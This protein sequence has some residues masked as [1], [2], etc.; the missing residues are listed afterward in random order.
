M[1]VPNAD[2]VMRAVI[3]ARYSSDLQAAASI[4][5]QIRVCRE[6]IERDG[7]LLVQVY[8]DRAVSGATLIRPG[9]QALLSDA[10]KR[11]F[12]L[13]YVESLD[14]IS[15]DQQDTPGVFKRLHFSEVRIITLEDGDVSELH[16]GLK[17]T[18]NALFL[19]ALADKTRRGLRGRVE[20]GKSGGGLTYGYDVVRT[21]RS[22]GTIEVG[23]R[24]VNAA[25]AA[26]VRRIFEAYAAGMPPRKIARMLNSEGIPGPRRRGWGASTIHGNAARGTGI[27]NNSLYVGKFVWNKLKYVKDPETGRRRSRVN[28][29]S[30]IVE[31]DVPE[32]RVITDELWNRVKT[33]QRKVSFTVTGAAKK[34]WDR[35]RPRYL[36]S[37]LVK[38]GSCG[39]GYVTISRT[40]LGCATARNKGLCSNHRAV[41]RETLEATIIEALK[42]RLM[43]PDLFK[44][45]CDEFIKE[46]NRIRRGAGAERASAEI[47]LAKIKKRQRQIVN[48]IA[49]GISA[50]TLKDE[51]MALEAREDVLIAKLQTAPQQNVLLNPNMA[52]IYRQRV[53]VLHQA[54][55]APDGNVEAIEA[56]RSLIDRIAVTPTAGKLTI[57]LYGEI[58]AILCMAAGKKAADVPVSVAEQLVMVAGVGFEPTTFRL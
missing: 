23:G 8:E 52:E 56:V 36:L 31:K 57:D 29:K 39:G 38:C 42:T 53:A 19:K 44:E 15:R 21:T 47:E 22:D 2:N 58:A 33:R 49:D 46:V 26:V 27:L 25:E 18:M 41:A 43:T 50:R 10:T 30:V 32:L 54:L 9:I 13:V 48:A 40:H 7:H 11:R 6:R 14:R 28:K 4:E 55:E 1:S 3:Y 51:L 37:G 12:D 20:A 45:F 24:R 35:R 34:P 5:D 16:I 17:G